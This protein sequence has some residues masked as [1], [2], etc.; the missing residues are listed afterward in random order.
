MLIFSKEEIVHTLMFKRYMKMN[1]L[2][3][4]MDPDSPY[5]AFLE[6]VNEIPPVY[7]ILFTL[8]VE[9]AAELNAMH[10]TQHDGVESF[11]RQMFR[12]HHLEEVRHIGFGKR[13]VEDHMAQASD[14]EKQR[15]RG[16]FL[17]IIDGIYKEITFNRMIGDHTSFAFPV[18]KDDA[19]A[20]AEVRE[21][22]HSR[23][24]NQERFR[25][26]NRWLEALGLQ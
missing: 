16:M 22:E 2:P 5:K 23:R 13:L 15:V 25:D 12:A 11:T 24:L 10:L 1:G 6:V 19:A 21:T 9:W 7:G 17:P 26:M 8:L 14:D 18:H 3:L 20:I 4:I